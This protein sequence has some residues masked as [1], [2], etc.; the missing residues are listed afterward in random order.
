MAKRRSDNRTELRRILNHEPIRMK[1]V[2][3]ENDRSSLSEP[4]EVSVVKDNPADTDI[5][6][7][8]TN[9]REDENGMNGRDSLLSDAEQEQ[10]LEKIRSSW[11]KMESKKDL[12]DILNL[13]L[14]ALVGK[15]A[16]RFTIRTINHYAYSS[17][18]KHRYIT[19][20][21]PKKMKGEFRTIDAPCGGLKMIQRALNLV[22]QTVYTPHSAAMGF[23]KDRSVVTNARVHLCQNYVYNIDLKDFFPSI[24]SGRLFARLQVKPFGLSKE[25]ASLITDIC[26]YKN[27]EKKNVLPQ[28][29]PTSPTI[30]NFICES[31]DRKLTRLAKAYGMNYTRYADD[32][33]FSSMTNLF[34]EDEKFCKSLR[35]IIEEEEHFEINPEKT[36]LCHRGMRQEVT[37]LTVNER[38]NTSRVYVKQI[39]MLLHIWE[40]KGISA[41]QKVFEEHYHPR[42]TRTKESIPHVENVLAGKLLYL[43]MVKG[44]DDDTYKSLFDRLIKVIGSNGGVV[45]GRKLDVSLNEVDSMAQ[46]LNNTLD[47]II[48]NYG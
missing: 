19:F 3:A 10:M 2:V 32:I 48:N 18:N 40:V 5:K 29:A 21:V 24:T 42:T 12:V 6:A 46:D 39:R 41:A 13:A 14:V 31:L 1:K 20:K 16:K 45:K 4:E 26:C 44:E 33:T 30:T 37:G 7:N 8:K 17:H 47:T 27:A 9:I 23:V 28:G 22:F 43:K 35:H 34:S 11:P 38:I 25:V 15:N 36:R